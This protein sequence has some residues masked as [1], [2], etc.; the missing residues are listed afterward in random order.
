MDQVPVTG[1]KASLNLDGESDDLVGDEDWLAP[2][3]GVAGAATGPVAV[4][5][6]IVEKK[7]ADV[8]AVSLRLKSGM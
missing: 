8:E 5:V 4:L 1:S 6:L 2:E 7:D 3:R